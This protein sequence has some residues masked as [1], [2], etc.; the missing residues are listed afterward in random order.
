MIKTFTKIKYVL[1]LCLLMGIQKVNAQCAANFSHTLNANGNVSFQSTSTNTSASTT[2]FWDFGDNQY[3]NGQTIAHTYTSNGIF[4]VILGIS[5]TVPSCTASISQTISITTAITPTCQLITSFSYTNGANGLVN[6]AS[7]SSGTVVGTTY[8]WNYGDS[9]TGSGITSSHTY[10]ANGNYPVQLVATNNVGCSYSI[11]TFVLVSNLPCG[12]VPNFVFTQAG[13]GLVTFTSTSTGTNVSSTFDWYSN[14]TLFSSVDPTSNLFNNGTYTVTLLVTNTSTS[15][16]ICSASVSQIITVNSNTCN[17]N[18]S[19]SHTNGSAG[20]VNFASTSTG[21]NSNMTYYWDFGDGNNITGSS[22]QSHTYVNAGI[23]YVALVVQDPNNLNCADSVINTVTITNV[24]CVAN[25]N[26]TL[27]P[28]SSPGYWIA[29]PAYPWNVA[30]ATWSWGDNTTSNSLITSHQYTPTGLYTICLT[31]S[32]SCGGTASTCASYS[33]TRTSSPMSFAYVNV[34]L[35]Q[36]ISL[37]LKNNF[38]VSEN[39]FF[40]YPNPSTGEFALKMDGLK[41]DENAKIQIYNI[42]GSLVYE[43]KADLYNGSLNKDIKLN[44]E[45][46]GLYFVKVSLKNSVIAKKIIIKN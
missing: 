17:L 39:N 34:E 3:G 23:Y 37:G 33:I 31:V 1:A 16:P 21:T 43:I 26:F 45:T 15:A 5:S 12:L 25:A 6:F 18:A 19:F 2:Y 32:V 10:T 29:T 35:P 36:S 7:T 20:L 27:T 38:L 28:T 14:N 4:T 13:N 11:T 42:T 8:A 9:N 41:D 40:V 30:S 46:N 24:P 22:L 44:N